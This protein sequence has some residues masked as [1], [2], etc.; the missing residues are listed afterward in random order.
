MD[1]IG[2]YMDTIN[3]HSYSLGTSYSN[4]LNNLEKD[5]STGYCTKEY[6]NREFQL[7]CYNHIQLVCDVCLSKINSNEKNRHNK[8]YICNIKAIKNE[9]LLKFNQNY[10]YFENILI[11]SFEKIDKLSDIN[12]KKEELKSEIKKILII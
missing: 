4:I 1:S 7:Y 5:I 3:Q 11:I 9:K 6:H 2:C 12:T 10:K 8:C